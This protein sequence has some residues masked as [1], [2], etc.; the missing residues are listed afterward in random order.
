MVELEV[1][2]LEQVVLLQQVGEDYLAV[3]LAAQFPGSRVLAAAE[4]Q[5]DAAG[6]VAED[7]HAHLYHALED[8]REKPAFPLALQPLPPLLVQPLVAVRRTEL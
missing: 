7:L 2:L 1:N 4:E 8:R 3:G 6:V 5:V